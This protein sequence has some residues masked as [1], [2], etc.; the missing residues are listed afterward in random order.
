MLGER[1]PGRD[2]K[3][4]KNILSDSIL[5]IINKYRH[6]YRLD[7]SDLIQFHTFSTS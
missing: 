1:K 7:M 2:E 5:L 3:W 4:K 6:L